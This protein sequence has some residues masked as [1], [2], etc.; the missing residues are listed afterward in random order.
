M[1]LIHIHIKTTKSFKS[2]KRKMVG[3]ISL[4]IFSR[5]FFG[6]WD[7]FI[8]GCA[9]RFPSFFSFLVIVSYMIIGIACVHI[10]LRLCH[11]LEV[12]NF[13]K[14]NNHGIHKMVP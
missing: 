2:A 4:Y 7:E 1:D 11:R 10:A 9:V 12:R 8:F 14:A 3:N 6:K 13:I 5:I